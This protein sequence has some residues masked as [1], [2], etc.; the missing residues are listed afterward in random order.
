M[1]NYNFT[2]KTVLITAASKGIGF[3]LAKQ[4]ALLGANIS[5]SSRNATN[6]RIAKKIILKLKKDAKVFTIKQDL[7]NLNSIKNVV[8]KSE[9]YFKSTIDILI[10]NSGG[11]DPKLVIDT[12]YKDWEKAFNINLK[13]AIYLSTHV[14]QNMR[15]KNWGRI[16]NLTSTT[17]KEP[18]KK[19]CLSN[20]TRSGLISFSKTLSMEVAEYG[21]TVNSI[22]TGGVLTERLKNLLKKS[23]KKKKYNFEKEL[24][25]I[26][27]NIPV[28]RIAK[29]DEFIQLILFLCSENSSYVNGTAIPIDGGTSKGLF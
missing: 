25:N 7:E 28:Q 21:I 10:N 2:N 29:P 3:E 17:A 16:I 4:L 19:M 22:L 5:I 27:K 23:I 15:K 13:S 18:A 26:S 8:T 24:K 20:I 9:K 12:S 11:P 6:L 14:I 1:I